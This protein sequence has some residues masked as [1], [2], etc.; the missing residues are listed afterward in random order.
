MNDIKRHYVYELRNK[1]AT[2]SV[3]FY[4]GKGVEDRVESH[5]REVVNKLKNNSGIDSEKQR[6]IEELIDKNTDGEIQE[7][8]VGRFDTDEEA[9][10][11]ESTLIDW[12]YGKKNLTNI[13]SGSGSADIR[14]KGDFNPDNRLDDL[15]KRMEK[16]EQNVKSLSLPEAA[17][18]LRED[19]RAFGMFNTSGPSFIRG[20]DYT[21]N[22]PVCGTEFFIEFKFNSNETVVLNAR[23][24]KGFH[25]D[26]EKR[27]EAAGY[28][29]SKKGG[30]DVFA[31]LAEYVK[32]EIEA[33]ERI[34]GKAYRYSS[35]LKGVP[36]SNVNDIVK[37]VQD[38]RI[39]IILAEI[40]LLQGGNSR[41]PVSAVS[42]LAKDAIDIF[43]QRPEEKHPKK[44]WDKNKGYV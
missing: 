7:L 40:T 15:R 20:Q 32:K 3:V 10:A 1:T 16:I 44:G 21:F 34:E 38:F 9:K 8:I 5:V 17:E 22:W 39:R 26:F 14:R 31:Q 19:L 43:K 12:V 35:Y 24:N 36:R 33:L 4:V 42:N 28:R 11:V 27:V 23:P 13:A 29:L 30:T 37:L 25:E 18:E 2:E 41:N 6:R